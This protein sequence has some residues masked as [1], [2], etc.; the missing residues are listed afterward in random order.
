MTG[1]RH[2]TDRV[3]GQIVAECPNA[4]HRDG[5]HLQIEVE[6]ETA[7]DDEILDELLEAFPKCGECG[8]ELQFVKYEEPT[9]VIE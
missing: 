2:A 7:T 3:D 9:E 4:E 5:P 8:E 6:Y 1:H